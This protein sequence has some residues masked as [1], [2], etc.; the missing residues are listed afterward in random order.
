MDNIKR[1]SAEH[2]RRQNIISGII[3]IG[4]TLLAWLILGPSQTRSQEENRGA[5][6]SQVSP[7]LVR[8]M[9][10]KEGEAKAV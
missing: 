3:L 8:I 4:G 5:E 1:N 10:L 7:A 2:I 9:E 6:D